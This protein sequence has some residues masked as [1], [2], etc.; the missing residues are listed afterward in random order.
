ME[1]KLEAIRDNPGAEALHLVQKYPFRSAFVAL[2]SGFLLGF[3][4][5][6]RDTLID[7]AATYL[8]TGSLAETLKSMKSGGEDDD[9]D[10]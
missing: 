1:A 7:G 9:K 6:L 5:T 8:N 4:P 10:E 2:G 3:S